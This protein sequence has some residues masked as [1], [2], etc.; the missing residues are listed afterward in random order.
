MRVPICSRCGR[1]ANASANR[2]I[3]CQEYDSIRNPIRNP[4]NNPTRNGPVYGEQYKFRESFSGTIAE[5]RKAWTDKTGKPWLTPK[6]IAQGGILIPGPRV[7]STGPTRAQIITAN[8]A[9]DMLLVQL[10]VKTIRP[11]ISREKPAP[12]TP[13][14]PRKPS[15]CDGSSSSYDFN[16]AVVDQN[17]HCYF[18]ANKF[19]TLLRHNQ[20]DAIVKLLPEEEHLIPK[21]AGGTEIHAACNICNAVKS[22]YVFTGKDDHRLVDLISREHSH[23]D[24]IQGAMCSTCGQQIA[25]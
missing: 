7:P 12:G 10:G 13:R 11:R 15:R 16:K 5:A 18:C 4:I 8:K 25:S 20:Y 17:G 9:A 1:Q 19:G 14:A 6:Q 24:V 23:Y 21:S 2:C 3:K 22:D